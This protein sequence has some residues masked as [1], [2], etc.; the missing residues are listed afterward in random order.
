VSYQ[1]TGISGSRQEIF[2]EVEEYVKYLGCD[3]GGLIGIV[4]TDIESLGAS[5]ENAQSIVDAFERY[6]GRRE[7]VPPIPPR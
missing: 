3:K 4:N 1:T 7:V 2:T 6:G 5:P